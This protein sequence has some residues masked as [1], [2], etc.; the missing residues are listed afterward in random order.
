MT[1]S[2]LEQRDDLDQ[3]YLDQRY[4]R[5]AGHPIRRPIREPRRASRAWNAGAAFRFRPVTNFFRLNGTGSDWRLPAI[6]EPLDAVDDARI[7]RGEKQ[8]R[9]GDLLRLA[10]PAERDPG[11]ENI[12][13]ILLPDWYRPGGAL[14]FVSPSVQAR[15]VKVEAAAEL[16]AARLSRR[17]PPGGVIRSD[18]QPAWASARRASP[19]SRSITRR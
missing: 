15:P 6:H 1:T 13:K 18:D 12:A 5:A 4:P 10:D 3:R 2:S 19:G 9:L 11:G 8:S 7:V 14:S 17:R 16:V